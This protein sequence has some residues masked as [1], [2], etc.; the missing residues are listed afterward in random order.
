MERD[1]TATEALLRAEEAKELSTSQNLVAKIGNRLKEDARESLRREIANKRRWRD[2]WRRT[3]WAGLAE[4]RADVGGLQRKS[5]AECLA[6]YPT[7]TPLEFRRFLICQDAVLAPVYAEFEGLP[8]GL[9]ERDRKG[10][11]QSVAAQAGFPSSIGSDILTNTEAFFGGLTGYWGKL[12]RTALIGSV[13]LASV[14]LVSAVPIAAFIGGLAGLQGAAAISFGLAFLGGG[15][16]V[17]GGMGMA[18]G[19]M[20]LG[21]GGTAVGAG[22][23]ARVAKYLAAVPTEATALDMAKRVNYVRHL[24]TVTGPS[25]HH[26]R[27]ARA[28]TISR[29]LD[30]KHLLE[31]EVL[32]GTL[33]KAEATKA[34]D[35]VRILNFTFGRLAE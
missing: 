24:R 32:E 7:G 2:T 23:G 4:A 5:L 9:Q 35:V 31:R 14:L 17:A 26:A 8:K 18:G 21:V 15:S 28:E 30:A 22:A 13:T 12:V 11:C 33:S 1:I 6:A 3:V 19:V 34:K 10:Q 20:V 27:C 25:A 16:L 29:F